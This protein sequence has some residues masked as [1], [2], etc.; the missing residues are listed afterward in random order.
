MKSK[1]IWLITTILLSIGSQLSFAAEEL[2]LV[3]LRETPGKILQVLDVSWSRN[4]VLRPVYI[5]QADGIYTIAFHVNGRAYFVDLSHHN[6]YATSGQTEEKIFS[7][8]DPIQ[9]LDFDSRGR[10]YFSA[11]GGTEGVIYHLNRHTGITTPFVAFPFR[12][13]ADQTRGFWNGYFAFSPSDKLFLSIDSP[14]PGG[15]SIYEYQN[16]QLRERF[17]HRERITGFTFIDEDTIYFTNSSNR[18]YQV[19]NFSA[20]SVRHEEKAGRML[21]DVELVK[22]PEH[23]TCTIS[24]RLN[25]GNE[26]WSLT[27]VQALGPNVLWRT[28]PGSSV[29]VSGDGSYIL[30][31]LPNGRYRISTDIRGDTMAGFEP[32][33]RMVNCGTTVPNMNF[34]FS[35]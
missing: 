30:R 33:E 35:H 5:R 13:L 25:G 23:G 7:S 29:R 8:A 3:D 15:S 2:Y 10:M 1:L 9:D 31:N 22:V 4:P 32:K 24:G 28:S 26:F 14:Q 17:P 27:S 6:I 19:K 18:V 20:V 34:S 12:S 16:G 21:N 11:I